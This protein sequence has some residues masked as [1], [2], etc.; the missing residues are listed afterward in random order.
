MRLK[1]FRIIQK[2]FSPLIAK[3][4]PEIRLLIAR[5]IPSQGAKT[6]FDPN[7]LRHFSHMN[8]GAFYKSVQFSCKTKLLVDINDIIGFRAA[9]N[10]KWDNTCLNIVQKIGS[11]NS[12]FIDIG[13]NVGTTCIPIGALDVPIVVFEPNKE[14]A[15]I[16]L[17]NASA[18]NLTR[19]NVL[20]VALSDLKNANTYMMLN[21]PIGNTGASSLLANWSLSKS[22]NKKTECYVST[23]DKSLKFLN[24]N[25]G[26]KLLIIK[27]DVEGFEREVLNG[28][29]E[30]I[31]R[32]R[33]IVIFENNPKLAEDSQFSMK[34]FN[35][36]FQKYDFF[37]IDE[38]LILSDFEPKKTCNAIAIPN[39]LTKKLRY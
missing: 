7:S 31:N 20:N 24:L 8:S 6:L 10:G 22:N 38:N 1:L 39:N 13:G 17:Q 30:T 34:Y 25:I 35:K 16:L 9:L 28:S 5:A 36:I 3:I 33:P 21:S 27:I 2:N 26:N 18:N 37:E 14:L 32:N 4:H 23:L 15:G 19:I 12:I 11:E 29:K